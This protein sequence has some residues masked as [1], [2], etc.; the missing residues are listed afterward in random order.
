[1]STTDKNLYY[2]DDLSKYKVDSD[3]PDVRGWTVK[4]K[5]GRVVGEVDKLLA[6]KETERVV[7]LDVEVDESILSSDYKPYSRSAKDGV[8]DFINEDGENH[9]IVPIGMVT[10][11][12]DQKTV[13]T[14]EIDHRTFSET[15]RR[16]KDMPVTREYEVIILDSY[17]RDDSNNSYEEDNSFYDRKEFHRNS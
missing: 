4:D 12:T 5:D 9:L 13:L 14:D 17:V 3:D 2:L 10:L 7:Y 1:M 8:H 16:R 11:D 15:K 6:N